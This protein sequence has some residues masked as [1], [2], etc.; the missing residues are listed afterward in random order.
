M[1]SLLQDELIQAMK[2]KDKPTLI[3]LRNI[4]GKIKIKI[5]EK[6][7]DLSNDECLQILKSSAKQLKDSITQYERG[8]RNDLANIEKFELSLIEK[9]LPKQLTEEEIRLIIQKNIKSLNAKSIQDMGRVMG[10]VM[11]KIIGTADGKIVK[12]IVQEELN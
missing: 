6:G 11:K 8:N 12:K 5:I 7:D 4:I 3:G 2:T 9:F 10:E 1:L